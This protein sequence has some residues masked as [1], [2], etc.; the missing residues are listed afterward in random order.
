MTETEPSASKTGSGKPA[1]SE[2]G[3][4]MAEVDKRLRAV[5]EILG[6]LTANPQ[7]EFAWIRCELAWFQI[8]KICEY[9]AVAIVFA[10]SAETCAMT[11]LGKWKPKDLLAQ[12]SKL[13]GHP[14]PVP[15]AAFFGKG[16]IGE[17]QII[18]LTRP[19]RPELISEIYGR[20]SEV[21]HVGRLDRMLA[22]KLPPFDL[23][24][25]KSWVGGFQNLLDNHVVLLPKIEKTLVWM[26]E[27]EPRFFV[28]GSDGAVFDT[29]RLPEFELWE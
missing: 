5:S 18:P 21:L 15:I 1:L 25:L 7:D 16:A 8:R 26:R 24:Q 9:L 3:T 19:M 14:T 28:L 27:Q 4:F 23:G 6:Q 13:S 10:H 22:G 12:V 17:K 20:C 2:Y 11:D 29:D